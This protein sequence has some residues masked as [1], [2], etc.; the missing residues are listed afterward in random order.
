MKK[1]RR[2]SEQDVG[3]LKLEIK[4][5]R[6]AAAI[7]SSL[8]VDEFIKRED[9]MQ[10]LIEKSEIEQRLRQQLEQKINELQVALEEINQLR[11][12]L[13]ICATCKKIRDDTGYWSQIETYIA[14]HSE[15]EFSHSICP[16]CIKTMYPQYYDRVMD[17][18]KKKHPPQDESSEK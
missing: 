2:D 6:E 3:L 17:R 13:P 4:Y 12:I 16:D 7:S 10:R 9:I 8:I 14:S 5:A 1:K 15:A 11:G 18:L